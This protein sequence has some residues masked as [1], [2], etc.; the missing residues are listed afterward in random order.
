MST[1]VCSKLVKQRL[2]LAVENGRQQ[3]EAL[4]IA[5]P[6]SLADLARA[7]ELIRQ[8]VLKIGRGL[9]QGWSEAADRQASTPECEHCRKRCA[10]KVTCGTSW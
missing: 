5:L 7:E 9:L 8:E 10:T 3:L 2:L 1:T 4:A 6:D